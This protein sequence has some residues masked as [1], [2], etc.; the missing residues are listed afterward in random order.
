MLVDGADGL[1]ETI[2]SFNPAAPFSHHSRHVRE[3]I[4]NLPFLINS[5]AAS[6]A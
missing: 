3:S 4:Q 1:N 5:V 2:V 6:S